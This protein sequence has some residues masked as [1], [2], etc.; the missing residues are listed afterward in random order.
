MQPTTP[1]IVLMPANDLPQSPNLA[2]AR[3]R[4]RERRLRGP[5]WAEPKGDLDVA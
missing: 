2:K 4:E 5:I 1:Q 3:R